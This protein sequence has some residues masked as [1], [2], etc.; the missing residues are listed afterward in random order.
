[1]LEEMG[2]RMSEAYA[3][4]ADADAETLWAMVQDLALRDLY[5]PWTADGGPPTFAPGSVLAAQI[6]RVAKYEK[7]TTL[8]TALALAYCHIVMSNGHYADIHELLALQHRPI[9]MNR[10]CVNCNCAD[11]TTKWGE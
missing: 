2:K 3:R 6:L 8:H 9:I 4:L 10:H 7:W 11:K 5:E 1:M